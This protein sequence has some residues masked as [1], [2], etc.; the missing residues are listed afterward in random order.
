MNWGQIA[1]YTATA[2]GITFLVAAGVY[3]AV[4]LFM[5]ALF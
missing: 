5:I 3:L 1:R 2:T 4:R